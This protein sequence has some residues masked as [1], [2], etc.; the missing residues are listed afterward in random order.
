MHVKSRVVS[1]ELSILRSINARMNLS[2][3]VKKYYLN[4]EKGYQGE[5]LFDQLTAQLQSDMYIINDLCLEFNHSVFQIDTLI[6][7]QKT[8]FTIEIKNYEG[9]YKYE[10]EEFRGAFSNHEIMNPLIQLKRTNSLLRSLLK[11]I[12]INLP[13]EGYVTFVNPEF[14]LYQAPLDSSIIFP[15]QLNRFVKKLNEMHSKL[16]EQHKQLAD[17]LLSMHQA[18]SPYTRLPPYDYGEL[19]KGITCVACRS[20]GITVGNKKIVCNQCG[21]IEDVDS[22]VLRNVEELRLLFPE[23]K[24]TT[25]LVHEWC[26]LVKSKKKIR[27]ILLQNLK[28]VGAREHRYFV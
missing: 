1:N 12:R 18:E 22:A 14:T 20:F 17:L 25:N 24:I 2:L 27:R 21:F 15:T 8:I 9:D 13:V 19:Q 28:S 7:S 16:N 23:K 26:K 11:S 5:V 4:I 3:K 10:S 6:I